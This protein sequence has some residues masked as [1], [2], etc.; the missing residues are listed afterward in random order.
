MQ[1][2]QYIFIFI[3]LLLVFVI[4]VLLQ[5]SCIPLCVSLVA[6][7]KKFNKTNFLE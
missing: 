6:P 5:C 1:I 7:L 3:Q 2:N 4:I